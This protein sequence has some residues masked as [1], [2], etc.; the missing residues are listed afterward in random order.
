MDRSLV[1]DFNTAYV[2]EA[3]P[4]EEQLVNELVKVWGKID[5]SVAKNPAIFR[6][7]I[8]FGMSMQKAI[9]RGKIS[10]RPI[11]EKRT[12]NTTV[13]TTES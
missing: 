8:L 5:L 11:R 4:E 6:R 1:V 7:G 2:E 3:T 10:L 9:A 12:K 13:K